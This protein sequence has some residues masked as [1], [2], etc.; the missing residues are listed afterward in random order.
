MRPSMFAAMLAAAA[1]LAMVLGVVVA[2]APAG[3]FA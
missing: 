1:T 3:L 2:T